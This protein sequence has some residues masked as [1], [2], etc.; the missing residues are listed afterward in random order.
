MITSFQSVITTLLKGS[1]K[2][3][4][5]LLEESLTISREMLREAQ[6]AYPRN[7][8]RDYHLARLCA[9]SIS[10]DDSKGVGRSS[11]RGDAVCNLFP[12]Q[13]LQSLKS[14]A[15]DLARALQSYM[16]CHITVGSSSFTSQPTTNILIFAVTHVFNRAASLLYTHTNN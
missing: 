2:G 7:L 15:V 3:V 4:R 10:C 8:V 5:S 11:S 14:K 16:H 12:P 6:L 1:N 9:S 13:V